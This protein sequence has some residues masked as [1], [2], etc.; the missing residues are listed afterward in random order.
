MII[1]FI[2]QKGGVGKSTLA[3]LAAVELAAAGWRAMIADLDTAQG[4]STEWHRIREGE[5]ADPA[6][7]VIPFRSV[8]RALREA[9]HFDA[10]LIDGPAHAER[11]AVTMARASTL[12]ILPVGY[13]VDDLRPQARVAHE[14]EDA[15]VDPARIRFAFCR[16][17]GSEAEGQGV[18]DYLRRAGLTAFV[19][20]LREL[21]SIRQ[22]HISGLCASEVRHRSVA[23][24]ARA[25]A[26]EIY[27]AA[28][29][30]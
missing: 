2:S 8:E 1:S 3:R 18:R 5:A 22:A 28:K 25:L 6:V 21:P 10:T 29:E 24:E 15:G 17:R 11:G 19:N 7:T 16:V 14:L 13:S 30:L 27:A 26:A 20:E 9:E 12:A 23:E 4:T